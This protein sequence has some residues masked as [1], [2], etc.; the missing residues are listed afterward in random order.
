MPNR[1]DERLKHQN[2]KVR[3]LTEPTE[4]KETAETG[5]N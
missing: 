5:Q 1:N 2:K 3:K 4:Y